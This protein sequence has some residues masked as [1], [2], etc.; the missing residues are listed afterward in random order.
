L[1]K[2][3][4]IRAE[5]AGLIKQKTRDE[6]TA[7]LEQLDCCCEPV[8]EMDEVLEHPLHKAREMFFTADG[9]DI[10]P[11]LQVRTPVGE[12]RSDRIAPRLGEHSA[13]VLKEYGF[14]DDEIA[15][16]G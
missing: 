4:A 9:G 12:P 15:A 8:L 3:D 7:R 13:E 1:A 16:L 5:L 14:S 2:Q 10:G 11:V 6:W